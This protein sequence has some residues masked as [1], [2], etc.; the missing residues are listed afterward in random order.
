MVDELTTDLVLLDINMDGIDA[1]EATARITRRCPRPMVV[2]VSTY[3]SDELPTRAR[4][5]GVSAY[6][7]KDEMSPRLLRQVWSAGGDAE[8]IGNR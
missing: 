6:I 3:T 8:W 4:E 5:C 2:L 1:I 7:N